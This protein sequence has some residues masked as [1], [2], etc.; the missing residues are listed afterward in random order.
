MDSGNALGGM[1]R[2]F[3][4]QGSGFLH[5]LEPFREAFQRAKYFKNYCLAAR[6]LAANCSKCR[7]TSAMVKV[8]IS[9]PPFS[10]VSTTDFK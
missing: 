6:S 10:P 5:R 2:I 1:S 4:L 8:C 3:P 7:S 9:R